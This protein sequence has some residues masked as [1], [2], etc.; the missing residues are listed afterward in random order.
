VAQHDLAGEIVVRLSLAR[1]L[2]DE[3]HGNVDRRH[4]GSRARRHERDQPEVV[5]VLV[6]DD[7]EL[8]VLE[9]V[10]KPLDPTLELVEGGAGVRPRI[11][12]RERRILDQVDVHPSDGKGRGDGEAVDPGRHGWGERVV[13][14]GR[15]ACLHC[16]RRTLPAGVMPPV[17]PHPCGHV[18]GG[19]ASVRL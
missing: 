1:E 19:R 8:D 5:D 11:D 3:R 13:A 15:G 16:V 18:C 14:G 4:L 10:P 2:L 12:Q 9:R 17:E 6:G 7:H